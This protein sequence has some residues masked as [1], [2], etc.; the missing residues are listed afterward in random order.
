MWVAGW[1]FGPRLLVP[2]MG[3]MALLVAAAAQRWARHAVMEGFVRG[4]VL[5]GIMYIQLVHAFFPELPVEIEN[6]VVDAIEVLYTADL[7]APN[8]TLGVTR[9]H[10]TASLLPLGI[11]VALVALL[12]LMRRCRTRRW[13]ARI[14]VAALS[15]STLGLLVLYIALQGP[16]GSDVTRNS[17]MRFVSDLSAHER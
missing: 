7:V 11:V 17:F 14:S 3:W 12:V 13:P 4:S 5:A 8:L 2:G 9:L 15:L 1:G 16:S 10:G 6:P